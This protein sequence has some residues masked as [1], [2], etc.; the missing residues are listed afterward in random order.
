MHSDLIK[1]FAPAKVNLTLDVL[2]RRADGYH[3]LCS[4]MASVNLYDEITLSPAEGTALTWEGIVPAPPLERNTAYLAAEAFR[5]QTGRACRIHINKRIPSRAGLGGGSA[6]AAAIL[7]GLQRLY[8]GMEDEALFSL[9][10]SVG[11]DVPFCLLGGCAL[12]EGIGEKLRPLPP[13]TLHLL[14]LKGQSG[15]STPRLFR[16][17]SLPLPH[18]DTAAALAALYGPPADLAPL[19]QNALEGPAI[20]L[21][22]EIGLLKSRLYK[23]GALCAF[24]TGSGAAV[25]GLFPTQEAARACLPAFRDIPFRAVCSTGA[26]AV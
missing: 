26:F 22:P 3:E 17:L 23:A 13:P 6:D 25:A 12:A 9:G 2:G 7:R 5:A 4:I 8:G 14:L 20:A 24:M 21:C 16:S 11:A 1:L 15:V 19:L 18:P 10:R